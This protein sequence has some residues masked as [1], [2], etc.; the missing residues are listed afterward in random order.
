MILYVRVNARTRACMQERMC[1]SPG[2]VLASSTLCAILSCVKHSIYNMEC[3]WQSAFGV[4]LCAV[5][6]PCLSCAA[7][8]SFY[9]G[10]GLRP[11]KCSVCIG[12][13]TLL[14]LP[15]ATCKLA[16]IAVLRKWRPF[17]PTLICLLANVFDLLDAGSCR[18]QEEVPTSLL[19]TWPMHFREEL[20]PWI[21]GEM[22]VQDLDQSPI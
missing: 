15:V 9:F 22:E 12:I 3:A 20:S 1:A 18:M 7:T 2:C 21:Q 5:K 6:Q 11:C 4:W 17:S 16:R 19:L 14:V 10:W 8:V 13:G